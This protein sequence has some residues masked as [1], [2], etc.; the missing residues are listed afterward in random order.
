[1]VNGTWQS[2]VLD[3]VNIKV[4]ANVYKNVPYG[5]RDRPSFT[6]LTSAKPVPMANDIWQSL[7][8]CLV[9]FDVYAKCYQNSPFGSRVMS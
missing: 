5:S 8:R 3:L 1:M 4:F 7:R 9:N 6:F 2:P